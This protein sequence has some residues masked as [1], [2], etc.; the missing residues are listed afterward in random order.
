[1]GLNMFHGLS[2]LPPEKIEILFTNLITITPS[3]YISLTMYL[4]HCI[5]Y[6]IHK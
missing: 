2:Y 6:L 4:H 5:F 1:M 3:D